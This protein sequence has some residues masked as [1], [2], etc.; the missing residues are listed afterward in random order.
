[1]PAL[2]KVEL[3]VEEDTTLRE[4]SFAVKV[5]RQKRQRAMA[6]RLNASTMLS[7]VLYLILASYL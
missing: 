7:N 5:P 6:V 3:T 2:L 1:M 4:L